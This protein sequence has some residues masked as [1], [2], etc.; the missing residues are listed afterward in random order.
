MS[1]LIFVKTRLIVVA[2]IANKAIRIVRRLLLKYSVK[3]L[4][5]S[6]IITT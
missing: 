3:K 2:L 1:V 5:D 4:D 6:H